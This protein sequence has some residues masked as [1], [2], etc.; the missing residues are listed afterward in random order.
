MPS[1]R[2]YRQAATRYYTHRSW[3]AVPRIIGNGIALD[4]KGSAF[5][6]GATQSPDFPVVNAIQPK[7]GG[8]WD[9]FIA[10]VFDD[11]SVL[12]QVLAPS[13]SQLQF[14]YMQGGPALPAQTIAVSGG[15]FTAAAS[16]PWLAVNVAGTTAS[17]S[18][19]PAGLQPGTYTGSIVLTPASRS[20]G[21]R[22]CFFDGAGPRCRADF[23]R[24][25]PHRGRIGRYDHH[26]SRLGILEQ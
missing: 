8:V 15:S 12:P 20:A 13:P 2:K 19:V 10:K 23:R 14:T 25:G 9:A 4:G 21:E 17:V 5:V 26:H 16:A 7:F 18:V 24:P 11:S 1:F 3:G 22:R 6:V